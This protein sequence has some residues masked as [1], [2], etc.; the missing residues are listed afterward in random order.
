MLS[1]S[2]LRASLFLAD[3]PVNRDFARRYIDDTSSGW[4][5]FPKHQALALV[6]IEIG[7][8]FSLY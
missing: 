5:I 4:G 2:F 7:P 6:L 3:R 8:Y 1:N